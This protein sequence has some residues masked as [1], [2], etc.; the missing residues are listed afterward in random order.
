MAKRGCR[1]SL[2]TI[3]EPAVAV[4][5]RAAIRATPSPSAIAHP[6]PDRPARQA[7][8]TSCAGRPT[9]ATLM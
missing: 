5:R 6:H 3:D 8:A 2:W 7:E 1:T 4:S 9:G